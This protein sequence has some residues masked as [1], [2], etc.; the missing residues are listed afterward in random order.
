MPM[1]PETRQ[2]LFNAVAD[3]LREFPEVSL[4]IGPHG[5]MKVFED[6]VANNPEEAAQKQDLM[7]NK[8]EGLRIIALALGLT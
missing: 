8:E 2:K 3:S 5:F 1:K 4:K 7:E 6:G